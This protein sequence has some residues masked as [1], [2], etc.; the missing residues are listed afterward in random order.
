MFGGIKFYVPGFIRRGCLV[1]RDYTTRFVVLQASFLA[2]GVRALDGDVA[3]LRGHHHEVT[4]LLRPLVVGADGLADG[5]REASA[6]HVG[7]RDLEE[8]AARQRGGLL[9]ERLVL[10]ARTADPLANRRAVDPGELDAA[11]VGVHVDPEMSCV[12]G[13]HPAVLTSS[14]ALSPPRTSSGRAAWLVTRCLHQ[15]TTIRPLP[16]S[17]QVRGSAPVRV[18]GRASPS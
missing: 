10:A 2:A 15:R 7:R 9:D 4:P 18:P 12:R 1:C 16:A 8:G 17:P 6:L 13:A 5:R 3:I 11:D 14:I